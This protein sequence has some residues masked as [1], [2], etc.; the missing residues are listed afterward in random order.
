MASAVDPLSSLCP[1]CFASPGRPCQAYTYSAGRGRVLERYHPSRVA[2]AE[3]LQLEESQEEP[4]SEEPQ[5]PAPLVAPP[6]AM[7]EAQKKVVRD[8]VV[9]SLVGNVGAL[10]F[11][12][13]PGKPDVLISDEVGVITKTE[14]EQGE[15][16]LEKVFPPATEPAFDGR[17]TQPEKLTLLEAADLLF[18]QRV[19]GDELIALRCPCGHLLGAAVPAEVFATD[20]ARTMCVRLVAHFIA[21]LCDHVELLGERLA[22][23]EKV[24]ANRRGPEFPSVGDLVASYHNQPCRLRRAITTVVEAAPGAAVVVESAPEK[25]SEKLAESQAYQD[26]GIL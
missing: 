10:S 8:L 23:H 22:R 26:G 25:T 9:G 4:M 20:D 16:I 5:E 14:V 13:A 17:L 2:R 11:D 15:K 12:V 24:P 21:R 3:R 1:V 19:A 7:S 18:G 6:E